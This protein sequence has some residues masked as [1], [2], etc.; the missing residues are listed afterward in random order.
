[1]LAIITVSYSS[2]VCRSQLPTLNSHL[3]TRHFPSIRTP[4]AEIRI[5]AS[6]FYFSLST[7]PF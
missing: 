1:V 4:Q 6:T 5:S 3:I 7:F 2:Y